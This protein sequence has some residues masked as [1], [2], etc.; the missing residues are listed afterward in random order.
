[1]ANGPLLLPL[2]SQLSSKS[3]LQSCYLAC[4]PMLIVHT[5]GAITVIHPQELWLPQHTPSS[6]L[7]P[8]LVEQ[9]TALPFLSSVMC[10]IFHI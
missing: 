9:N 10:G 8:A 1:M 2:K 6:N 7:Q 4:G 3:H 5:E